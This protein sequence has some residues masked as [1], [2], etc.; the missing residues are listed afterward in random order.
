MRRERKR[1]QTEKKKKKTSREEAADQSW[2]PTEITLF[3]HIKSFLN[4]DSR[5]QSGS[6]SA[7]RL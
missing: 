1:E 6:L 4:M 5:E 7:L 3:I 2:V